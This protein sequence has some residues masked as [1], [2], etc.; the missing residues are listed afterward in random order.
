MQPA[1]AFVIQS[2]SLEISGAGM[3]IKNP[4]TEE[5]PMSPTILTLIL[6]GHFPH[7]H[8]RF[9]FSVRWASTLSSTTGASAVS[10]GPTMTGTDVRCSA[11]P[12]SQA[13]H[14]HDPPDRSHLHLS[15]QR[16]PRRRRHHECH[17]GRIAERA[18]E[19]FPGFLDR[20]GGI[21]GDFVGGLKNNLRKSL[22]GGCLLTL[23]Y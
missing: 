14:R 21:Y 6:H 3:R 7:L 22:S 20:R 1:G 10:T 15:H 5:A 19:Q 13:G 2:L 11:P 16:L 23:K 8:N 4:H 12:S 18:A 17:E 9:L